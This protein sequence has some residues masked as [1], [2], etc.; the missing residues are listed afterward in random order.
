MKNILAFL[1]VLVSAVAFG[2]E[3]TIDGTVPGLTNEDVYLMRIRGD[4]RKIVDTARTDQTGSF[5]FKLKY[6]FPVGQYAVITGPKQMIELIFNNENIRFVSTGSSDQD[7]VQIIES[8]ENMIYYNYLSAKG[9]VLYKLDL[10]DPVLQYYPKSDTFYTLTLNEARALQSFLD[11]KVETLIENNPNTLAARYIRVDKPVFA[12]PA[13]SKDEQKNYLKSHYFTD[14]DFLDTT[15]IRSNILTSKIISY[16]GLYQHPGMTKEEMEDQLLIAVD[17][18]MERAFVDQQIYEFVIGFM[19]N[20]FEHIGFEKGLKFIADKNMLNEFCVNT[21]KKKELENKIELIKKLAIGQPAP[22]FKTV[23]LNGDTVHLYNIKAQT[24]I[25]VFWAS[26][27]PHCDE[28]LPRL[29]EYYDPKN[30]G[31]LQII[32]VSVDKSKDDLEKAIAENGYKWI[33]IGELKGWE[34]PVVQEYGVV[35]TPTFFVL[36]KDKKIIGKPVKFDDLRKY[37]K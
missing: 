5:E 35:A 1:L 37:L 13:L 7:Q 25:L 36:D 15:L 3:Y 29:K 20:G 9:E 33:N 16:M 34:G 26:W 24:V 28:A 4:N 31:K 32:A 21:E 18:I 10:L 12:D 27:C 6:D 14:M 19:L 11:Q 23:D 22:D 2:Q 8:V 17:T 30:T